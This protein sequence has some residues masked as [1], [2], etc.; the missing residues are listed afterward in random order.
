MT[1]IYGNG[2]PLTHLE[3]SLRDVTVSGFFM[4]VLSDDDGCLPLLS[5]CL[6]SSNQKQQGTWLVNGSSPFRYF[7]C[8]QSK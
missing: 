4:T 7:Q 3:H 8:R 1:K 6:M 2:R 5:N